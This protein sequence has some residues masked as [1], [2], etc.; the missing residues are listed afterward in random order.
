MVKWKRLET[1]L[2]TVYHNFYRG[3]SL[4]ENSEEAQSWGKRVIMVESNILKALD[5]DVFWWGVDWIIMTVSDDSIIS[6][7]LARNAMELAL[8][9]Q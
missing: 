3:E 8:S 5:Y 4:N 9:G 1:V 6:E 7:P 2:A